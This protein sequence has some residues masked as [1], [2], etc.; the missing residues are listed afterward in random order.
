[1]VKLF[2]YN[3]SFS[4]IVYSIVFTDIFIDTNTTKISLRIL[5]I[6]LFRNKVFYE[7]NIII[8]FL[9]NFPYRFIPF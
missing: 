2:Y 8:H 7:K 4:G 3:N 9:L 6:R 1:M 5:D